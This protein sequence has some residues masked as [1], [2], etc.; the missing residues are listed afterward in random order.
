MDDSSHLVAAG[1]CLPLMTVGGP[2]LVVAA[3]CTL[4]LEAAGGS[5]LLVAVD[6]SPLHSVLLKRTYC[7]ECL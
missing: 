3:T 7:I 2:F 4:L 1:V 6:D 5:L